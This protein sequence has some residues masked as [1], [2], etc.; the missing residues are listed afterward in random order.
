LAAVREGR[1]AHEEGKELYELLVAPVKLIGQSQ[2]LVII[3]DAKKL[4]LVAFDA[5]LDPEDRYLTETHVISYAPSATAYHL[6]SKPAPVEREQL[7]LLG[8]GGALY[9]RGQIEDRQFVWRGKGFFAPSGTPDWS[10]LPHSLSEVQD[11]AASWPG[12][13]FLLTEDTATEA[14]LKRL[15][16]SQFRVLHLAL[17]SAIDDEF[18]DRSALV[19]ASGRGDGEDGLLQARE[20]LS[21]DLKAGLVTLSACD[22]G[23]GQMEGIAGMNSLV[24]AFLMAGSRSVVASIWA[25]E[26]T[27][28]AA[29]M[30]RFYSKLRE[31]FDKAEALTLAKR[32]LLQTHRSDPASYLWAGFRLVGDPHGIVTGDAP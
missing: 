17:H 7:A 4:H 3:P 5:L 18:P 8:V 15:P 31:G 14:A 1:D 32:E 13:T 22:A 9:S 26:D 21:L 10:F 30:R 24:Q 20:I 16:L 29:L 11:I 2:R 27:Y 23:S 28:T 6:L 19:F 12:E 25:A